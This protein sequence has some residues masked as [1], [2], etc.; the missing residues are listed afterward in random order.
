MRFGL[1]HG[2][3]WALLLGIC[4]V[5][6]IL[7][8]YV[9][10]DLARRVR[11]LQ[12][13]AGMCWLTG[14]AFSL[15]TAIWSIQV[16]SLFESRLPYRVGYHPG[17]AVSAWLLA[18]TVMLVGLGTVSGRLRRLPRVLAG[19]VLVGLGITAVQ[20]FAMH[21]LG[22]RPGID[23]AVAPLALAFLVAVASAST[24]V[25]VAFRMRTR[26]RRDMLGTQTLAATLIGVGLVGSQQLV[27][28]AA[29]L[30]TQIYSMHEDRVSP[31]TLALLASLGSVALLLVA[32][33]L[34]T[35]EAHL[36]ASLRQAQGELER[37]SFRDPM[38]RLPNRLMLESTLAQ[39]A[40]EVDDEGGRLALLFIDLDG[41]K[42]VNQLQ[43][44]L[45][46]DAIL[47]TLASRLLAQ[48][49]R[50]DL[51]AHLGGDEFVILVRGDPLPDEAA[52]LAARLLDLIGQPL[53]V[54][55]REASVS[56]SIGVALYPGDST[57]A[58]LIGNAEAAMRVAKRMGGAT[59]CFYEPRMTSS[60][61]DQVELLRDLRGALAR[62]ELELFYQPKVH[63]PSGEITGV[64]ALLRWQHP[65]RG[66]V[67][68]T[69]FIPIAE[70]FGLIGAMGNWVIDQACRQSRQWRDQGLLMRVAVNL[71]VHQL[72]SP[73]LVD[74]ISRALS[75]HQ[76]NPHLLT[77]E[78][79]ESVAMEDA[80][81]AMQTSERLAAVGV[82]ISI[83]DF[84]TG[85]SSLAYLR[86]L[87]AVE[88]K[89]DRSFVLDLETSSDARAVVDGVIKLAQ[90]LGLKVVA[91]GVET[92]EQHQILRGLGCDELQGFLFARPMSA[93]ALMAWATQA[94]DGDRLDF[95]DSL[96]Q[97]TA[98][99]ALH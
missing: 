12:T 4:F 95:R 7:G 40:Q 49:K 96:Y 67:S 45:A 92:D 50:H 79:T 68:P 8:A 58:T 29:G 9:A 46:G 22:L 5:V 13:T 16:V 55:G 66:M 3:A 37:Q 62:G 20:V 35:L 74:R 36:R 82:N 63:A 52:R 84:G 53:Q 6:G 33:L 43:G 27:L 2:A 61:R 60:E 83:D 48:T 78:I 57:L 73:D 28:E 90:A 10:L 30:A 85:Y 94:D 91:E 51:V 77:C 19:A 15:G 39:A 69:V 81:G 41:F 80:E 42:L 25:L 71:S 47:R 93:Q 14:A 54:G 89:I 21:S 17:F 11:T 38:T 34:S 1:E 86:K 87:R 56:S 24:S 70:R 44:H 72:R 18:C 32:L 98:A 99:G 65:Q 97:P 26:S 31:S 76:V 64:E 75:E 59:Y 23:W 88:L